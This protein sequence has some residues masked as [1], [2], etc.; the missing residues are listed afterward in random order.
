MKS[1]AMPM[2][3]GHRGPTEPASGPKATK[4]GPK[5]NDPKGIHPMTKKTG[6]K[7]MSRDFHSGADKSRGGKGALGQKSSGKSNA[8]SLEGR[9]F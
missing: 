3:K 2:S 4:K 7:K 1:G 8:K 9:Y 6:N 5:G